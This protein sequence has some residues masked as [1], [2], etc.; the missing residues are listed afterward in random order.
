MI[1]APPERKM[2]VNPDAYGADGLLGTS[3]RRKEESCYVV[4]T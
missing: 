4:R 3:G 1:F 2:L